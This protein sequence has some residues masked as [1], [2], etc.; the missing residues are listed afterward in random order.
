MELQ[1]MPEK[2]LPITVT[3]SAEVV[4]ACGGAD[5][6]QVMV[7]F[8]KWSGAAVQFTTD[9]QALSEAP[10][11][12]QCATPPSEALTRLPKELGGPLAYGVGVIVAINSAE[13]EKPV[14]FCSDVR[15]LYLPTP[16]PVEA[17]GR[18]LMTKKEAIAYPEETRQSW[19]SELAALPVGLSLCTVQAP[20]RSLIGFSLRSSADETVALS[21]IE[22]WPLRHY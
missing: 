12:L 17:F 22:R 21:P 14:A 11:Q 19:L 4:Q 10:T 1:R 20:T 7:H 13:A 18:W 16:F 6:A 9:P 2:T 15:V 5:Q 8:R 3:A